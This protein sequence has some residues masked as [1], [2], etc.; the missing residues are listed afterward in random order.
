LFDFDYKIQKLKVKVTQIFEMAIN[1]DVLALMV[2]CYTA[3]VGLS[4]SSF[5]NEFCASKNIE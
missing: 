5:L 4:V 1:A 2:R 3:I